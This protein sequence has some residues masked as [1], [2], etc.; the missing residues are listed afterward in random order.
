MAYS[1][2]IRKE[3]VELVQRGKEIKEVSLAYNISPKTIN[4]WVRLQDHYLGESRQWKQPFDL[5]EKVAVLN[6]VEARNLSVRQIADLKNISVKTIRSWIKDKG[7]ILAVYSSQGH[8]P[9]IDVSSKSPGEELSPL[10]AADD[11][12]IKQRIR[13]LKNE[14]EFLKARVAYLEA[15]M[16]I[17]GIP[18]SEFKK[19]PS[20]RPLT[21]SSDKAS[22]T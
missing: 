22:E 18:A 6:L 19:K 3:V 10:C 5:E 17:K 20:T 7:H 15:F 2:K 14:N 1:L 11:K 12:V 9:P 16:E 8:N 21:A 13:D 4:S